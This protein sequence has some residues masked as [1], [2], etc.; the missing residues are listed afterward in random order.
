MRIR[1]GKEIM[2]DDEGASDDEAYGDDVEDDAGEDGEDEAD[3]VYGDRLMTVWR[4]I[5]DTMQIMMLFFLVMMA[6]MQN[7]SLRRERR[8]HAL[9]QGCRTKH[10][11]T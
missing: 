1:L 8:S 2:I 3:G 10:G 9:C 5:I 4:N 6:V 11:E 7:I